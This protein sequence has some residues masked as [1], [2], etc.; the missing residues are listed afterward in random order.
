M[1]TVVRKTTPEVSLWATAVNAVKTQIG[2]G[3]AYHLDVSEVTVTAGNGDGTLA[4]ALTLV[5]Q[6]AAVYTFHIADAL[7]HKAADAT[8]VLTVSYPVATLANA[9]S[10]ANN[11]KAKYNL[12][13]ASTSAHFNADITNGVTAAD[14]T[15]Q[16]TLDTLI[17][18]IKAKLNA[19][20]GTGGAPTNCAASIRVVGA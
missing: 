9:E 17:T 16:G 13:I 14:A 11:I 20:F 18:Q 3:S 1:A 12:H 4:T 6:L 8:D 2:A 7:A 5:N 19:H 10:L 15:D